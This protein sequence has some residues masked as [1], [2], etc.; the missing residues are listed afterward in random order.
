MCT[1]PRASLLLF[2]RSFW[3]MSVFYLKIQTGLDGVRICASTPAPSSILYA[4]F[5]SSSLILNRAD[6]FVRCQPPLFSSTEPSDTERSHQLI[7]S[8]PTCDHFSLQ[9]LIG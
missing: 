1:L 3:G 2:F 8:L 7:R 9:S 6:S 4:F 5:P